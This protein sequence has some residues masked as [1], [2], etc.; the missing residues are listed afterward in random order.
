M[1]PPPDAAPATLAN[2]RE[3]PQSRWAFCHVREI[4]P[5]AEIAAG[6]PAPLPE[7]WIDLSRSPVPDGTGGAEGL[8]AFLARTETTAC[9]MLH[10]GRLAWEWYAPGG[11]GA[12][13]HLLFSVTKSVT[14][15]LAG[16]LAERGWLD[17]DAPVRAY[18][19]EVATGAYAEARVRHLLDMTVATGF[20]E[21]YLDMAGAYG[22]Y[23]R[24]T[25]WNP[26]EPGQPPEDLRR[27][28][29]GL[30]PSDRPHGAAVAYVSPNSDLLGWVLERA[31]RRRVPDLLSELIWRPLG[32]EAPASITVDRLGAPRTGGGMSCRPRDLARLGEAVRRRGVVGG[33]HVL[34]GVWIDDLWAGG[35]PGAWAAGDLVDLFPKGGYRA[36]WYRTG[37]AS[38][39]ITAI[40]IHG[41]WLWI[42]PEAELVI[43]KL[44]AQARPLDD[45]T[46]QRIIAAFDALG[47]HLSPGR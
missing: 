40:G 22:R 29:T 41:Q 42:D 1:T 28:L 18:V 12:L 8:A 11:N 27:F 16:C 7:A 3:A 10:R 31:A 26:P 46:D 32:A 14:G 15:L 4:V 44:S 38:G 20:D 23:R 45:A 37:L 36:Q 47:R 5:T 9:V 34:P 35:D 30:E 13:P 43:A 21:S 2:W 39:A 17:P 19:P 24:A 25:G 6:S 33:Q